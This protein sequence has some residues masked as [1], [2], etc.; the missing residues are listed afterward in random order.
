MASKTFT[1]SPNRGIYFNFK[2]GPKRNML[3]VQYF[4]HPHFAG[5]L[6]NRFL[7]AYGK[8]SWNDEVPHYFARQFYADFFMDM[9]H[10]YT[11]L[12]SGYY[13]A[14]KGCTYDKKWTYRN[15]TLQSPPRPLI[16]F[17]T[18]EFASHSK[19]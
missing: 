7:A 4:K 2:E 15:A 11:S 6:Y 1:T 17:P 3:K 18:G 12:P 13:G 16:S 10:D 19:L 9:H 14:G 5:H 8:L